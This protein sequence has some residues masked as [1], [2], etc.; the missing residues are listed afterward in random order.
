MNV[1]VGKKKKWPLLSCIGQ[2]VFPCGTKEVNYTT[3]VLADAPLYYFVC[4]LFVSVPAGTRAASVLWVIM[5]NA[6]WQR[7]T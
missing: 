6:G 2:F 5:A 7:S 3:C 1:P 4:V